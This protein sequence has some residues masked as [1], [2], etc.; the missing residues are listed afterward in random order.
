MK[1]YNESLQSRVHGHL[2]QSEDFVVSWDSYVEVF[3][4]QWRVALDSLDL[5]SETVKVTALWIIVAI[6]HQTV[7]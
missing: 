5:R 4:S 1:P 7:T 3:S 2:T 6:V